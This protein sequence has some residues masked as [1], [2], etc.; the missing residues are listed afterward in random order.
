L[1][2][3][4]S[5]LVKNLRE[6]SHTMLLLARK[7]QIDAFASSIGARADKA[8][9]V[10]SLSGARA[11]LNADQG[12][13]NQGHSYARIN[14]SASKGFTMGAT[15]KSGGSS[16]SNL[17][18]V[19]DRA[20]ALMDQLNQLVAA[21]RIAIDPSKLPSTLEISSRKGSASAQQIFDDLMKRGAVVVRVDDPNDNMLK[22]L[23]TEMQRLT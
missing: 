6:L 19:K 13:E 18:K 9:R 12:W 22:R 20:Q 11:A 23:A 14:Y 10:S 2:G 21:N 17:N 4:N 5:E 16:S 7:D 15:H 3:A 8:I 1:V